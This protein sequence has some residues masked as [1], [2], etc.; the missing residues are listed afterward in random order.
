[1]GVLL[2]VRY[3]ANNYYSVISDILHIV[4]ECDVLK[5]GLSLN[6][7][8]SIV[9]NVFGR[10]W[11]SVFFDLIA[12]GTIRYVSIDGA[13]KQSRTLVNSMGQCDET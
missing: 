9:Q 7:I 6:V 5:V 4:Y 10:R 2:P 1:M 12:F 8:D 13:S 11:S 3:D